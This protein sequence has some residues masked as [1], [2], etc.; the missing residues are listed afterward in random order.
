LLA[1]S[2]TS[3]VEESNVEYN[4]EDIDSVV[5]LLARVNSTSNIDELL[6]E[7]GAQVNMME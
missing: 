1:N 5:A 3:A 6:S 4:E 7:I 2:F